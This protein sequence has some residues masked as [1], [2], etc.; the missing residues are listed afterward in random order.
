LK[1]LV[2]KNRAMGDAIIGLASLS[3][4]RT[5]L[6]NAEIH[7]ALPK[8]VAPLFREGEIDADK[9]YPLDLSHFQGVLDFI[10]YLRLEK[11]DLIIELHQGG[12]TGKILKAFSLLS[13][14]PY[15]FHNHHLKKNTRIPGQ[16]TRGPAI[17]RDLDGLWWALDQWGKVPGLGPCPFFKNFTPRFKLPNN[18]ASNEEFIIFGV[19]ATRDTKIWPLN[20]F[21]QMA[22]IFKRHWPQKRIRIPLS[23][24]ERD[25]RIREELVNIGLPDNV[26]FVNLPLD[27]VP[28]AMNGADFYLGNDTGLKHLAISLGIKTYTFFGP[29]EPLEWHPYDERAH[30]Y[31]FRTP[32]ECRT[33]ESHY[34]G[35]SECSSMECLNGFSPEIVFRKILQ[36][37]ESISILK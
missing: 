13:K 19:V 11:F 14:T 12:K 4:I 18:M 33:R 15:Y 6:S 16:G 10:Q 5:V 22:Y 25:K 2:V 1:V 24:S 29:E 21:S 32:L 27:Q 28:G 31:F 17:Q 7:Y 30:P 34:C 8:W 23:N 26:D 20:Y 9:Q 3:Y 37:S 36:E 35:L